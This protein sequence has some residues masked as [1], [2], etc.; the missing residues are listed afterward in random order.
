MYDGKSINKSIRQK[1]K[2][3]KQFKK[4]CRIFSFVRRVSFCKKYFMNKGIKSL[5]TLI[6][7]IA[8]K[9]NRK[10]SKHSLM[11]EYPYTELLFAEKNYAKLKKLC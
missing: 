9:C 11:S 7:R 10:V 5:C 8:S 4:K 6:K 2:V 3:S 1:K